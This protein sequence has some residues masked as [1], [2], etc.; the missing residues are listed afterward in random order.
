MLAV[1]GHVI[2]GNFFYACLLI[3]KK[4]LGHVY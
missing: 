1:Y 4:D 2:D 3:A